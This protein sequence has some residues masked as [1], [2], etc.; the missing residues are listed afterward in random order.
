VAGVYVLAPI[1]HPA[2]VETK[3]VELPARVEEKIR[4]V[5]QTEIQYVPKEVYIQ[6]DGTK[7]VEKTDVQAEIKQPTVNVKVNGKP[8]EFSLLQG[9]SQKFEQGKVSL[10]QSSEIGISLEVK[11]QIID[12]TKTGGAYL[13]VGK[14]SGIGLQFNRVGIDIGTNGRDQDYRLRWRAVEW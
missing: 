10:A 3:I 6:S 7:T 2:K 4:T 14:Y 11:P 13:F 9:E 5:T 12:R 1:F 8:Y